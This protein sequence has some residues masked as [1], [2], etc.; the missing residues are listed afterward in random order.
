MCSIVIPPNKRKKIMIS[1]DINQNL[2]TLIRTGT[3][4]DVLDATRLAKKVLAPF[5]SEMDRE[6]NKFSVALLRI[7]VLYVVYEQPKP[8]LK[9]ALDLIGNQKIGTGKE[10]IVAIAKGGRYIHG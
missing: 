9:S 8:T 4:H 3:K 6:G 10:A 5:Q 2:K 1:A 7:A